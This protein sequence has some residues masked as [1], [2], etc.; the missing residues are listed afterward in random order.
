MRR[1]YLD[2]LQAAQ[3]RIIPPPP[4]GPQQVRAAS[5][6]ERGKTTCKSLARSKGRACW[7]W[8]RAPHFGGPGPGR[9]ARPA[10]RGE[11]AQR[12]VAQFSRAP[13]VQAVSRP[14]FSEGMSCL[15]PAIVP[16]RP[17]MKRAGTGCMSVGSAPVWCG[18][19]AARAA[20]APEPVPVLFAT[21]PRCFRGA[22]EGGLGALRRVARLTAASTLTYHHPPHTASS[23]GSPRLHQSS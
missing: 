11:L 23:L 4:P 20:E 21:S 9:R 15:P 13:R 12:N 14:R 19:R 18:G 16:R 5:D 3:A 7:S 2:G 1:F 8:Q 10:A 22:G 6:A 17:F